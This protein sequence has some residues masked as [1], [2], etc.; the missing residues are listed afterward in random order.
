MFVYR[1]TLLNWIQVPQ[2]GDGFLNFTSIRREH[3]GWYKCTSRHL[4]FHYSSI[5]YFLS[6]RC[7]YKIVQNIFFYFMKRSRRHYIIYHALKFIHIQ[8]CI[9][10]ACV[11]ARARVWVDDTRTKDVWVANKLICWQELNEAQLREIASSVT[12]HFN[13]RDRV[14]VYLATSYWACGVR[15]M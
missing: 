15:F 5:G 11:S 13:G 3:S 10:C 1:C 4:N 14:G 9:M 7:K 6:V 2:T 8:G 12:L